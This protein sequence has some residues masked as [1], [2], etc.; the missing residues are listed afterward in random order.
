MKVRCSRYVGHKSSSFNIDI[1]FFDIVVGLRIEY[2]AVFWITDGNSWAG[3]FVAKA[4][5]NATLLLVD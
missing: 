1:N 3:Y 5:R 4:F 2:T